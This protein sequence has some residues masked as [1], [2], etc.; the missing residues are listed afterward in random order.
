MNLS[1][2]VSEIGGDFSQKIAEFSHLLVF[3]VPAEGVNL[4]LD[5]GIGA[6]GQKTRMMGLPGIERSLTISLAVW[7]ESANVTDGQTDGHMYTG[8]QQRSRLRIA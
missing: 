5:L 2:T 1:G 3:W 6:W 8:R 4:V 7:I